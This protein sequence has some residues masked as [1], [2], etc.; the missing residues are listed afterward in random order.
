M[1]TK[2]IL[3][4]TNPGSEIKGAGELTTRELIRELKERGVTFTDLEITVRA[5]ITM[6]E[7]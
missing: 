6:N 4:L 1:D 3:D 7:I 5:T 2:N